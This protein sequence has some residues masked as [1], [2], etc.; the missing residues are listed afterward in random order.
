MA[1][2]IC[3][4]S[5][6]KISNLTRISH[7]YIFHSSS[8]FTYSPLVLRLEI[9]YYV[10]VSEYHIITDKWNMWVSF[11]SFYLIFPDTSENNTDL[12][13]FPNYVNYF[14]IVIKNTIQINNFC[15][16]CLN[17]F[18]TWKKIT[19]LFFFFFVFQRVSDKSYVQ[20]ENSECP[21]WCRTFSFHTILLQN[22]H[23]FKYPS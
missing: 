6:S 5:S 4:C 10:S 16:P 19:K 21:V 1:T 2:K 18:I 12:S 13:M 20:S 7:F 8:F 9:I 17:F 14:Y 3:Y 11:L 22:P 23:Y 15:S